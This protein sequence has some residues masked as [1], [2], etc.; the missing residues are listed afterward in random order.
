VGAVGDL[1]PKQI[2]EEVQALLETEVTEL[3]GRMKSARRATV[4]APGGYRNGYGKPRRLALSNG[5]ITVR[6]PRV[7]GLEERFESRI[8]PLFK[9]RPELLGAVARGER[10]VDGQFASSNRRVAA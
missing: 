6:R 1:G 9:R 3:L 7:R 4:D 2:Q 5:M 10:C 8:L